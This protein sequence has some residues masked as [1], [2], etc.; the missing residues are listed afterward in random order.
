MILTAPCSSGKFLTA[1]LGV[2]VMRKVTGISD[3]LGIGLMPLTCIMAEVVKGR[4]D[5]AYITMEGDIKSN[6]GEQT[7]K[8]SDTIENLV[9]SGQYKHILGHIESF[10]TPEGAKLLDALEE[11][12]KIVFLFVDEAQ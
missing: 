6:T 11:A 5:V 7:V 4:S 2:D 8:L 12:S 1:D 9:S 10:S 3:G